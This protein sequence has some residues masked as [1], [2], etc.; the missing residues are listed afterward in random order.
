M[1]AALRRWPEGARLFLS[2]CSVMPFEVAL[3]FVSAW[4]GAI[5][6]FNLTVAAVAFSN[7]L[8]TPMVVA[9]NIVY[10]L[11]GVFLVL[12]VGWGYRNIEAAGMIL[13]ATVL[14]VRTVAFCVVF[15]FTAVTTGAIIQSLTFGLAALV[16]LRALLKNKT[17]VFATDIPAIVAE[18]TRGV[19]E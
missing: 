17:L 9:F 1:R 10:L 18:Q 13:L 7:A 2:R 12:G 8:P 11:S 3:G 16:R 15:G 14:G 19:P 5:S 4:T 6:F